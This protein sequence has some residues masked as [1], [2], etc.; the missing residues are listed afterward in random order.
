MK[1]FYVFFEKCMANE[2]KLAAPIGKQFISTSKLGVC[3]PASLPIPN[4]KKQA[5]L[6]YSSNTDIR[7]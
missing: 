5:D 6:R 2:A 7:L 4:R 3:T 1:I